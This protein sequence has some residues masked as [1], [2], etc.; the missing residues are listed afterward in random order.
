MAD[1]P[2]YLSNDVDAS[3]DMPTPQAPT[4]APPIELP[5]LP[6]SGGVFNVPVLGSI[7]GVARDLVVGPGAQHLSTQEQ[8]TRGI[9]NSLVLAKN[10]GALPQLYGTYQQGDSQAFS[11]FMDPMFQDRVKVLSDTTGP[12]RLSE[13]QA[14]SRAA[15]EYGIAKGLAR[16]KTLRELPSANPALVDKYHV[17]KEQ[18]GFL[19][20]ELAKKPED[21]GPVGA[22]TADQV[23]EAHR[24]AAIGSPLDPTDKLIFLAEEQQRAAQ[25]PLSGVKPKS[26]STRPGEEPRMT[27]EF[28]PTFFTKP[29]VPMGTPPGM[30]AAPVGA[31]PAAPATTAPGVPPASTSSVAQPAPQPQAGD[32]TASPKGEPSVYDSIDPTVVVTT[33]DPATGQEIKAY[34][35]KT[36]EEILKEATAIEAKGRELKVAEIRA[37]KNMFNEAVY[38]RNQV[39][40]IVGEYATNPDGT[41]IGKDGSPT[42]Y[43]AEG[44]IPQ[45]TGLHKF[46]N[47]A[48]FGMTAS[49]HGDG[50]VDLAKGAIQSNL[51]A[52][53]QSLRL[54]DT[55]D[56]DNWLLKRY[57]A[58]VNEQVPA[59]LIAAG[60][61]R[62]TQ[63]E[64]NLLK[65]AFPDPK[66]MPLELAKAMADQL[67][68]IMEARAKAAKMRVLEAEQGK[69]TLTPY[70]A[71]VIEGG[72]YR[73]TLPEVNPPLSKDELLPV[74]RVQS[75]AAAEAEDIEKSNSFDDLE[76]T[77]E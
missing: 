46:L 71:A 38:K 8:V 30:P 28:G 17:A 62:T 31:A 9:L 67:P 19:E 76:D 69:A 37:A 3:P 11:Q 10:P 70:P 52:A 74:G 56:P 15:D 39:T 13:E 59:Y 73:I 66:T 53:K 16:P 12:F 18:H 60:V 21:Y 4:Q 44:N 58:F 54:Q 35:Y 49:D 1:T 61:T 32:V 5:P 63:T 47:K 24:K 77:T 51:Y 6:S 26:A 14:I 34:R 65:Q 55:T 7:L 41:L 29:G 2:Y 20:Q 64:I 40:S 36:D 33:R 72:G 42:T 27:Y 48:V 25:N 43:D 68:S 45:G 75:Q 57:D 23:W 50:W 22:Y